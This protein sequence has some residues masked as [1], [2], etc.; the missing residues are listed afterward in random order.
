MKVFKLIGLVLLIVVLASMTVACGEKEFDKQLANQLQ[1]VLDDAVASP[2]TISPGAFMRVSGPEFGVWTG[3]AGLGNIETSTAM[4]PDDK[5]RAGSIMKP[6]VSVVALQLVEEGRFLLEDTMTTVLPVSVTDRFANSNEITI[7]MLLNHTSGIPEWLGEAQIGEIGANPSKIWKVEELLDLAAAQ[8]PYFA[9]GQGWTYSNTDYNLL[10]LIIEQATGRSWREEVRERII[11]KLNLENT[12]LP[13]PGDTSIP[14]NHARGYFPMGGQLM[15]MTEVDPSMA[16]GGGG[17]ALITTAEDLS[18]FLD[19]LL[20]GELFQNDRTLDEM[21]TFV[22]GPNPW[23]EIP[24][25]GIDWEKYKYGLGLEKLMLTDGGEL[26]GH[27]GSTAGYASAVYYLP[28]KDITIEATI[29]TMD[30]GSFLYQVLIPALN[31]LAP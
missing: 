26:I 24:L 2:E 15:D 23:G 21:M 18:L 22:D 19:A 31:V 4:R 29:N 17:H 28:S 8:E 30:L 27:A 1:A 13:E 3:A 9:P 20:A 10:T 7:R 25:P 11:E 12:L 5:L 14:G 6:L 16:G